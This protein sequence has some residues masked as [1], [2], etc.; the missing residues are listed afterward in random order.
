MFSAPRVAPSS[1]NWTPTTPTLS[2]AVAS[3]ATGPDMVAPPAGDVMETVGGPV[4]VGGGALAPPANAAVI[5][6]MSAPTS[7]PSVPAFRYRLKAERR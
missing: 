7:L 4:S 1:L 6:S 5:A 2:A 3:T